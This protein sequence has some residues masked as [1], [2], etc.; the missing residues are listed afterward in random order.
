MVSGGEP[1]GKLWGRSHGCAARARR[2]VGD[3]WKTILDLRGDCQAVTV[4][5]GLRRMDETLFGGACVGNEAKVVDVEKDDE[6]GH[7]VRM[8]E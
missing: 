6:E 1:G 5:G 8:R 4:T 3:S 7:D 2:R